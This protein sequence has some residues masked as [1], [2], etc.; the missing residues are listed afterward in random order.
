LKSALK[1]ITETVIKTVEENDMFNTG[2]RVLAGV[3]GGPDSVALLGL[4][5]ELST[6]LSITLGIAHLNHCLRPEAEKE[7]RF[8]ETLSEKLGLPFH[9]E[10]FDVNA[11]RRTHGLSLEEAA[12]EVRYTFYKRVL[13]SA[14]YQKIALGH[15]SEDNAEMV[16][17]NLLRGSGP[18]GLSGI[19]PV[20]DTII[21]RPLINLTRAHILDY[22]RDR[23]L[24]YVS[25]P[26]NQDTR[27]TRNR[28]RHE[29]LPIIKRDFNDNI[30]ETLHRTA[31]ITG[32]E[33]RWM[34]SVVDP[35]WD[36]VITSREPQRL[37]LDI[38]LLGK[39]SKAPLRRIVR[40]AIA[41]LRGNLRGVTFAHI[42]AIIKLVK[43]GNENARV[44]LPGLI[45]AV[46]KENRLI[47]VALDSPRQ[48]LEPEKSLRHYR[49]L[50]E[51]QKILSGK[52]FILEI[53]E[54]GARIIFNRLDSFGPA[55]IRCSGHHT[56]FFDINQLSF[57]LIIRNYQPGDRFTPLGMHGSKKV[58]KLFNERK[59]HR[60]DRCRRPVLVS[61]TDIIWVIGHQSAE[62]CKVV[63]Q[64]RH[65][66]EVKIVL[67]DGK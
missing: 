51:A 15:H 62:T 23:Q 36:A 7:A 35:L 39:F 47:L 65:A 19:P 45:S 66:L 56:A 40:R 14:G 8:V 11:Y 6:R 30:I 67:P 54:I 64:T 38:V 49:H 12:R 2:D 13:T 55:D 27:F 60:P 26:S 21:V 61:G 33:N 59:V 57:P 4:L 3:S 5:N 22:L 25:D 46:K 41:L 28:I 24:E 42:E 1:H 37:S 63:P 9:L 20:R 58:K 18:L 52:Q 16:L 44:D 29:L 10:K 32:D 53:K 17:M 50:I 31:T 43:K 48:P 34:E